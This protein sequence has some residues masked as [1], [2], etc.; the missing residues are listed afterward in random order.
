MRF[1][2]IFWIEGLVLVMD[3]VKGEEEEEEEGRGRIRWGKTDGVVELR[4]MR[5]EILSDRAR[6]LVFIRV[7]RSYLM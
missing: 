1:V 3:G 5:A 7:R 4:R 6:A 2:V